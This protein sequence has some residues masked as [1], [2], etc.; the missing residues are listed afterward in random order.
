MNHYTF[1]TYI[2]YGLVFF[3]VNRP[4]FSADGAICPNIHLDS[5]TCISLLIIENILI[6]FTL[7]IVLAFT[8]EIGK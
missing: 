8:K 6:Y 3:L 7:R 1:L 2:V 5:I 4:I